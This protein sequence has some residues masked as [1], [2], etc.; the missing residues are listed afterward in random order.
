MSDGEKISEPNGIQS[1]EVLEW[2]KTL[3]EKSPSPVRNVN[4]SR[5][6][7]PAQSSARKRTPRKGVLMMDAPKPTLSKGPKMSQTTKLSNTRKSDNMRRSTG[8]MAAA[9]SNTK[10]SSKNGT[11]DGIEAEYIKNL[12]QQIYFLELE[13]NYLRE[14]AKKA[15]DMHPKMSAEAERMLAKLR[16]MQAEMDGLQVESK[17]KES[18]ISIISREK[19]HMA[20]RLREEE[21]ARVQDKR[22]LMDEVI[23]LKKTI[24]KNESEISYKDSQLMDARNELE[25]SATALKNA[26][27]KIISLKS[28]LEQRIEQHKM[29]QISLDEKRSDLLSVETQLKSTEEKYYNSTVNLQ[30]KVVNDLR[31]EI[32]DLR[33]KLKEAEMSAEQERHLRSK[34]SD[35]S[36]TIVRENSVLHQQ[37]VEMTKQLEREKNLRDEIESRHQQ[38]I[39]E[40]VQ[41]KE[42][43]KEL[44]FELEYSKE[45][46][47][48]EHDR[49]KQYQEKLSFKDSVS[50]QQEL[51]LNTARSRV[52]EL[53]GMHEH[54]EKEN[55]QLRKDKSLLVDHVADIQK[56]LELKNEEVVNLRSQVLSLE[57]RF[58]ELEQFNSLEH[59]SQSQKWEE[60]EKLAESMRTLSHTMAH[61]QSRMGS[62]RNTLL[63]SSTGMPMQ[64]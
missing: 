40:I 23:D 18:S 4:R 35:D 22:L 15:T 30:D 26:E 9:F 29:T 46:M 52:T 56:K 10:G 64:F 20:E 6:P 33:I 28:Q 11:S 7:S 32:R 62:P 54:L 48:K 57:Q 21:E 8:S 59:T 12:Q 16:T 63:R 50:T 51:Q 36:S 2:K 38:T 24:A 45:S 44:R 43:E 41:S 13:T 1:A 19:A 39:S 25:K 34:M 27:T 58:G 14:Q 49:L 47:T 42:R 53:T 17:R 31:E 37:V 60:F 3:R 55:T 5:S 61:S